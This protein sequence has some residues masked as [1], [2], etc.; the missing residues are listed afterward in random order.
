M[1]RRTLCAVFA[2]ATLMAFSAPAFAGQHSHKMRI[3][4]TVE[5]VD[6][7]QKTFTVKDKGGK[8]ITFRIDD[9]SELEL[10]FKDRPDQNV[11]LADLKPGDRIKV[12]AFRGEPP[13]LVDDA[14]IYR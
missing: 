2:A 5:S 8:T 6:Q 4:G 14:E 11:A 13:H 7:A 10:D 12:K 3:R 1:L 9:R